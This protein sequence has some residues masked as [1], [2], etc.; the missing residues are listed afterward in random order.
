VSFG[1]PL[2]AATLVLGNLLAWIDMLIVIVVSMIAV[3]YAIIREAISLE[4]PKPFGCTA[5]NA[6]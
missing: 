1:L 6:P 5:S 4:S 3:G 2:I